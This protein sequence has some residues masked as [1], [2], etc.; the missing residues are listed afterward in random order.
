VAGCK[1][2]ALEWERSR[3]R[4]GG[5]AAWIRAAGRSRPGSKRERGEAEIGPDGGQR[6]RETYLFEAWGWPCLSETP[7][8]R[9]H[10]R[11]DSQDTGIVPVAHSR[12]VSVYDLLRDGTSVPR[13]RSGT[14]PPAGRAGG[15][16]PGRL[17]NRTPGISGDDHRHN[18]LHL[19][20]GPETVL[21][22][23]F[24]CPPSLSRSPKRFHV[25]SPVE[26]D[27]APCTGPPTGSP[28]H[29]PQRREGL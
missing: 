29:R 2:R 19:S 27:P 1:A 6:P 21:R 22:P 26:Q 5:C 7:I 20:R 28:C 17:P 11:M 18:R 3:R 13:A 23:S 9:S 15:V 4:T 10:W 24:L 8:L 25:M 14:F 12:P 16:A